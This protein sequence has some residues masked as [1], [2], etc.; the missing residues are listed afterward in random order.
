MKFKKDKETVKEQA[1]EAVAEGMQ[2][3][4]EGAMDQIAGGAV[5]PFANL[6]RANN[7]AIDSDLRSNG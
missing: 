6:P 2:E 7:Q 4:D 3:L 1:A 5:N